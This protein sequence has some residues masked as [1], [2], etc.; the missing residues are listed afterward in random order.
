MNIILVNIILPNGI[1]HF[2]NIDLLTAILLN[3]HWLIVILLNAIVRKVFK[4]YVY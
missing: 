2:L 1:Q 3:I 4:Q